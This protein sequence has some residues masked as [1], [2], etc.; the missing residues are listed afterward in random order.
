MMRFHAVIPDSSVREMW[1]EGEEAHHLLN[2][3]RA[4]PGD[5]IELFNGN[6][7]SVRAEIVETNRGRALL[8][9]GERVHDDESGGLRVILAVALPK[10]ERQTWLVEKITELGVAQ[11]VPLVTQR[12]VAQP[13]ENACRRLQ[14]NVIQACKQSGRNHLLQIESP[15]SMIDL[16]TASTYTIRFLADPRSSRS[17]W[18]FFQPPSLGRDKS[19]VASV[20]VAI[21]PEGGFT[22]EE[23]LLAD[24]SGWDR[25]SFGPHVLRVETAAIAAATLLGACALPG[26]NGFVS[27]PCSWDGRMG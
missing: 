11:L 6:G 23:E 1:L 21:G 7:I 18:E 17:M 2:V 13:T 14:R 15:R 4:K 8:Q 26:Q 10:G 16:F 24:T 12:G 19:Q 25:I 22:A 20:C 3:V 5:R 9:L 27:G